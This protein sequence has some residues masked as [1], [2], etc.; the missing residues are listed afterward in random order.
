MGFT[1]KNI[2]YRFKIKGLGWVQINPYLVSFGYNNLPKDVHFTVTLNKKDDVELHL[3]R[4]VSDTMDKPCIP[5]LKI[6][7]ALLK[8]DLESIFLMIFFSVFRKIAPK[9]MEKF[10]NFKFLSF[11]ELNKSSQI[12]TINDKL[13]YHF[14]DNLKKGTSRLEVNGNWMNRLETLAVSN[15]I[16]R[17][18]N[19][20]LSQFDRSTIN[21]IE[22][23][24]IL[25]ST[26]TFFVM[27]F[28]NEWYEFSGN[29]KLEEILKSLISIELIR[30]IEENI[31]LGIKFIRTAE[32]K[33]DT[34]KF[35]PIILIRRKQP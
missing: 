33:K 22:G 21:H 24:I 30:H 2:K 13:Q 3:T 15:D 26:N 8:A 10:K 34:A 31:K 27:K 25:N 16:L 32:S 18:V 23:G 12:H 28:F 17:I 5:I 29:K 14:K 35:R 9:E 11:T 4:N 6:E 19:D 1:S 20:N 7:R